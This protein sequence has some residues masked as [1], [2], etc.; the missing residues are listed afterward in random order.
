MCSWVGEFIIVESASLLYG[1][2]SMDTY[3]GTYVLWKSRVFF[4]SLLFVAI[5]SSLFP[6]K[7][8]CF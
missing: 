5:Y 2:G 8:L 1:K 7:F 6:S 3:T 4:C